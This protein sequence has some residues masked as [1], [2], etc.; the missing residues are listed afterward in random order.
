LIFLGQGGRGEQ[1]EQQ[2]RKCLQHA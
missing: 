1:D 2:Q